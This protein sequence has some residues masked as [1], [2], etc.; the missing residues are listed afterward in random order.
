MAIS[1]PR[2]CYQVVHH[3]TGLHAENYYESRII[4]VHV[5]QRCKSSACWPLTQP[6]NCQSGSGIDC[7]RRIGSIGIDSVDVGSWFNWPCESRR[8]N[9]SSGKSYE[10]P[11]GEDSGSYEVEGGICGDG[12]LDTLVSASAGDKTISPSKT[13]CVFNPATVA[14]LGCHLR[15][16]RNSS[17][18]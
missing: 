12:I 16:R 10:Q 11:R 4:S 14:G 9:A 5:A 15:G 2:Q 6:T 1:T 13:L 3:P 18:I 8:G 7:A 17:S